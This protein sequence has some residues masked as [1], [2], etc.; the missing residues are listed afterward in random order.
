M[1]SVFLH[2]RSEPA[3]DRINET[4]EFSRVPCVGEYVKLS[5]AD[6]CFRVYLVLHCAFDAAN[7][8]EVFTN[9]AGSVTDAIA[10]REPIIDQVTKAASAYTAKALAGVNDALGRLTKK[11]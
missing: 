11:K 7:T 5:E 6:A 8:A 4:R 3:G 1:V 9:P 10:A 2:Y